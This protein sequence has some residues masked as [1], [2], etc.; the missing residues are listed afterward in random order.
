[1]KMFLVLLFTVVFVGLMG[2]SVFGEDVTFDGTLKMGYPVDT[3]IETKHFRTDFNPT[4]MVES[5]AGVTVL[6][7][8]RA[9]IGYDVLEDINSEYSL[10]MEYN[11][12]QL[13]G[14]F[15]EHKRV[16]M[17]S[18]LP[19]YQVTWAGVTMQFGAK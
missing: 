8:L 16:D 14:V 4:Y 6:E 2:G 5:E 12:N 15:L 9:Y 3:D 1:M 18:G 7:V 17:R 13:Y 19:D 10:G 11:A